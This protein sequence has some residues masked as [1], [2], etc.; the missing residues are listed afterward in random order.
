MD[1]PFDCGD[2]RVMGELDL[3]IGVGDA[4]GF[5]NLTKL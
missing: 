1:V 3:R 5:G 4:I 2:Q